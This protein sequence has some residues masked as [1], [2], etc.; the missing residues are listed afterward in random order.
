M[1]RKLERSAKERIGM[2]EQTAEPMTGESLYALVVDKWGFSYD[3]QLRR[4]K[5]KIFL[6]VMWRYL[7]QVSFPMTEDE[8]FENLDAI[9]VHLNEWG[10]AGAVA[11]YID[12]TRQ[13]PRQGKVVSIPL[14]LGDRASEWILP[15]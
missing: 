2:S 1:G 3:L 8:Y 13:K 9:A 4:F 14:D 11:K 7:E 12:E 6:Q 10:V 15:L 5:G